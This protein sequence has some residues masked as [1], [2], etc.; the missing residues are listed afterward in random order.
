[1]ANQSALVFLRL[2]NK[3]FMKE[4]GNRI[5]QQVFAFFAKQIAM[6][7]KVAEVSRFGPMGATILETLATVL[8]RAMEFTF[9]LMVLAIQVIG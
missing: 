1:M 5:K 8:S 6:K 9:G 7:S 3:I 4:C 2:P